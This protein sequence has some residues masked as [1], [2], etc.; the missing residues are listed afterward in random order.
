MARCVFKTFLQCQL[1]VCYIASKHLTS[2]SRVSISRSPNPSLDRMS[3]CL[4]VD[5]MFLSRQHTHHKECRSSHDFFRSSSTDHA[6][7]CSSVSLGVANAF[8]CAGKNPHRPW[9]GSTLILG[10]NCRGFGSGMFDIDRGSR[11]PDPY[12]LLTPRLGLLSFVF[13]LH[14]GAV[15]EK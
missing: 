3:S 1:P 11:G 5:S 10:L 13:R 14:C 6:R 2:S 7:P 8:P 15:V 12:R 9:S 4:D